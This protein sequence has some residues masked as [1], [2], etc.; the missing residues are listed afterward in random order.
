M[1]ERIFHIQLVDGPI[2]CCGKMKNGANG[3]RLDNQG[4]CLVEV[5]PRPL[6]EATNDPS[7]L[8][9]LEGT[10]G[11]ELVLEHP[12]V[13]DDVHSRRMR[14]ERPSLIGL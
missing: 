6:L 9:K 11:A 4:E 10:I 7:G 13:R 2:T 3:C 14:H 5:D 12:F 1:V 8:A